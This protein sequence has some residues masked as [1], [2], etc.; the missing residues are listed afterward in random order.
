MLKDGRARLPPLQT[1]PALKVGAGQGGDLPSGPS[2][3]A[4][5]STPQRS[6]LLAA[7]CVES[8]LPAERQGT[9]EQR[10]ARAVQNRA[11]KQHA[12]QV[13]QKG[14]EGEKAKQSICGPSEIDVSGP[15]PPQEAPRIEIQPQTNRASHLKK[16]LGWG[17]FRKKP[18]PKQR[19][20]E[21]SVAKLSKNKP[22]S[23]QVSQAIIGCQQM[24]RA[25]VKSALSLVAAAE[26]SVEVARVQLILAWKPDKHAANLQQLLAMPGTNAGNSGWYQLGEHVAH[27]TKSANGE[28]K[29]SFQRLP[30]RK[31][32]EAVA[33]KSITERKQN[34]VQRIKGGQSL[35]AASLEK[36]IGTAWGVD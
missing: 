28:W 30:L 15:D 14:D 34:T 32:W 8:E 20:R 33:N 17:P 23:I 7:T 1:S 2:S 31:W 9:A 27:F 26:L 25:A 3:G 24:A 21:Q 16:L 6:R 19:R 35:N 22:S 5:F 4:I 29:Q 12:H 11:I 18:S 36:I 13:E 10:A